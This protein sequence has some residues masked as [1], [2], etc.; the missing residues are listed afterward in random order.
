MATSH[1]SVKNGSTFSLLLPAAQ[2]C[3]EK[4]MGC[5]QADRAATLRVCVTVSRCFQPVVGEGDVLH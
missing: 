2:R 5:W 1:E 3:H 4:C